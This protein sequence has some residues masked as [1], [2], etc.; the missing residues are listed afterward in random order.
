MID[1]ILQ[2]CVY[3]DYPL[4]RLH[5]EQY[6]HEIDKLILFP[7]RQHGVVD[8]EE[9]SRKVI[10]NATWVEP[11]PI[12]YGVEDW[13]QA[14]TDQCLSY[15]DAEWIWFSE[16]DFF[17]KDWNKFYRDIKEAMKTSDAIGWWN[18]T[19]FPYL[20]PCCLFIKRSVLEKTQK[21]FK[22]HPEINGAD[23]FA[24]ITRDL[25]RIGAK[26]TTLQDMGYVDWV[27]CFHLGGLTY[28][29]QD[30]KG[31]D[32][33]FGVKSVDAFYIY[34]KFL[35]DVPVEQSTE[36]L[37]LSWKIDQ[38]LSPKYEGVLEDIEP[39]WRPFFI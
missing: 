9:F 5:N 28:P 29:Y 32:T 30:F 15:S 7:S 26:I 17:V 14:E 13:R 31:N 35:K 19:H 8:L 16:Q 33:V 11:K 39:T 34:N 24:M 10:P 23:H 2:Y 25:E 37:D 38:I 6:H 21:D 22:A 36:F 27:D 3:C 4:F 1:R 12:N 20:H 18:P